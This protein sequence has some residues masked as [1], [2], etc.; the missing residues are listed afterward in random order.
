MVARTS[1]SIHSGKSPKVFPP[2][3]ILFLVGGGEAH[4]PLQLATAVI[5]GRR[6]QR[7]RRLGVK[8]RLVSLALAFLTLIG[9]LPILAFGL[10]AAVLA[11]VVARRWSLLGGLGIA[12]IAPQRIGRDAFR[13]EREIVL[14]ARPYRQVSSR[15]GMPTGRS[16]ASSNGLMAR[17]CATFHARLAL[18]ATTKGGQGSV[19]RHVGE[20]RAHR[21]EAR[22]QHHDGVEA[23]PVVGEEPVTGHLEGGFEAS[24]RASTPK[25]G[26]CF[27]SHTRAA[28]SLSRAC[29]AAEA[30]SG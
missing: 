19:H 29:R 25:N 21:R 24:A 14:G 15:S 28:A 16:A 17:S 8:T 6:R 27:M 9:A 22:L 10:V 30:G 23:Q 13:E 3:A 11:G 12:E 20:P 4:L 1:S 7:Q 18:L 2:E 5:G 26:L